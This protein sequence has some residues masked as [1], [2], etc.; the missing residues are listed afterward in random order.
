MLHHIVMWKFADQADG[1]TRAENMARCRAGLMAL[2]AKIPEVRSF[3]VEMDIGLNQDAF[4][5]CLVSTFD[6]AD[7]LSRYAI[8]PDHK[9]ISA[10]IKKVREGR[11]VIDFID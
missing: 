8:H 3:R 7:S 9:A 6:D 11:G 1:H 2:P 10:L 4:D 5:M